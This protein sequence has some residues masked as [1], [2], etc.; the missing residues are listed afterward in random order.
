MKMIVPALIT[1]TVGLSLAAQTTGS[2]QGKVLDSKGKPVP[3][4]KV[5]VNPIVGDRGALRFPE[6]AAACASAPGLSRFPIGLVVAS[7]F[8][9]VHDEISRTASALK[10]VLAVVSEAVVTQCAI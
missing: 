7:H 4:A 2:L 8:I 1:M 10:T 9:V 3:S 6:L 5:V